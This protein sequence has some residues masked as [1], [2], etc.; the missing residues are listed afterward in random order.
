MTTFLWM[1]YLVFTL[2]ITIQV[3]NNLIKEN[4]TEFGGLFVDILCV[5]LWSIW[6]FYYLH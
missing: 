1:L 3:I 2:W 5:V 4:L 6:Y